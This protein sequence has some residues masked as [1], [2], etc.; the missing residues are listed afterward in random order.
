[1]RNESVSIAWPKINDYLS[2]LTLLWNRFAF[3]WNSP[4]RLLLTFKS[5]MPTHFRELSF[6]G[7]LKGKTNI[8]RRK[9]SNISQDTNIVYYFLVNWLFSRNYIV[10]YLLH[11]SSATELLDVVQKMG[12][13][14]SQQTRSSRVLDCAANH[15]THKAW[16]WCA[17]FSTPRY[18]SI[19]SLKLLYYIREM[20]F[21]ILLRVIKCLMCYILL[22]FPKNILFFLIY[23]HIRCWVWKRIHFIFLNQL[24]SQ[25]RVIGP[26]CHLV[27]RVSVKLIISFFVELCL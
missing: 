6:K 7:F 9:I 23:F 25:N 5:S 11:F 21:K 18:E 1:M 16:L 10:W 12:K 17:C 13:E 27:S 24:K 26:L 8:T 14:T 20:V 2:Q 19:K 4:S 3:L 22:L 15:F